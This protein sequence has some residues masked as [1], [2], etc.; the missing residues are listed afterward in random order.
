MFTS[1]VW[2]ALAGTSGTTGM[3]PTVPAWQSDYQAA[4]KRSAD[5]KKPLAVLLGSGAADWD[6]LSRDG[7][8]I[9]PAIVELL[10][11]RYVPVYIDVTTEKGQKL[12]DAF[13]M[14]QG[15]ILSDRSG[16]NQAFRHEGVLA[17]ADLE[18]NLRRFAEPDRAVTQTETLY[19][20]EIRNYPA[21]AAYP[22]YAPSYYPI[23]PVSMGAGR[24]C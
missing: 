7:S 14:K 6:T 21:T 3:L 9:D 17:S 11:D 5:E 2:V 23:A 22:S 13:E 20:T 24:G 8:K 18:R 15:V 4:K 16:E 10:Q 12:A 1:L 19:R